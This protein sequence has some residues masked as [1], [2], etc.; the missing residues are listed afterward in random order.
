MYV[1]DLVAVG[2]KSAPGDCGPR[3]MHIHVLRYST[4]VHGL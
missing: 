3:S 1:V 2:R 4:S